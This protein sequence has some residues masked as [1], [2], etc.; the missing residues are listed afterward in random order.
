VLSVLNYDSAVASAAARMVSVS[1]GRPIAEMGSRRT[2]E[3]AA[4]AAAR[5]AYIAGFASTSNLEAGRSWG[6]P[7]MGTAAHS[8]TLL[9]DSEADAFEAQVAAFGSSTT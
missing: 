5:A 4:V 1:L 8:F 7:T 6:I 3:Y 9:H 2:S